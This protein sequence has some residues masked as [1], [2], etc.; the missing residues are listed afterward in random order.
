MLLGCVDVASWLPLAAG[1]GGVHATWLLLFFAYLYNLSVRTE[2][3]PEQ[4]TKQSVLYL[5]TGGKWQ[6]ERRMVSQSRRRRRRR[7]SLSMLPQVFCVG[8]LQ[9][10]YKVH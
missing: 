5:V 6:R 9:L 8:A 7:R 1:R 2:E 4:S 10:I 3:G